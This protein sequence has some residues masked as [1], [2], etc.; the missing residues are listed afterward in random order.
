MAKRLKEGMGLG[1][2][3]M[4]LGKRHDEELLDTV[5]SRVRS[6]VRVDVVSHCAC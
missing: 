2:S 3:A 1:R 6:R 4:L 5:P